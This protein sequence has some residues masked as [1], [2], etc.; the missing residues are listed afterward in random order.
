MG[1]LTHIAPVAVVAALQKAATASVPAETT[2]HLKHF[3]NLL[4]AL[5]VSVK[6]S[7]SN[8]MAVVGLPAVAPVWELPVIVL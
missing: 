2:D 6:C 4:L 3:L 7:A 8:G 1:C 5:V